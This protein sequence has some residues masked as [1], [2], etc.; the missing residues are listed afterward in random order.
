MFHGSIVPFWTCA[1]GLTAG[2]HRNGDPFTTDSLVLCLVEG[3][4]SDSDENPRLTPL[5][6]C[7]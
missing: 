3:S 4:C 7:P 2:R 5:A 6:L 1:G